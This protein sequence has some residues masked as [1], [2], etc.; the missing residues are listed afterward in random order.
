MTLTEEQKE[1]IRQNR[2]RALE[3]QRQRKK[4]LEKSHVNNDTN[5]P[6]TPQKRQLLDRNHDGGGS[7]PCKRERSADTK[8]PT[9]TTTT[10][11]GGTSQ[12]QDVREA[13]D[14]EPFEEGASE[15]VTKAE[16]KKMYCLPEGTLAVCKV[17]EKDNPRHK[18]WSK[19]KLYYR[20]ELRQR[21]HKR[22]DGREGLAAER[23]RREDERFYKDLQKTKN[24]F[25]K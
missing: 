7:S 19:M 11:S 20:T 3:I 13:D 4:E 21:A 16:A 17:V 14:L 25:Q 6:I 2:E 12:T 22:F 23:K 9:P 5:S 18:G 24:I 1:R 8:P 10:T 15:Y